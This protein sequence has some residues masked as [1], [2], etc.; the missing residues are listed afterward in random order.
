MPKWIDDFLEKIISN[1]HIKILQGGQV[2]LEKQ[3]RRGILKGDGL[4][5]LLF[6][7]CMDPLSRKLNSHFDKLLIQ[8]P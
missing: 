3:L 5:P 6:V 2:I 4:S 1:W 8:T 7:I